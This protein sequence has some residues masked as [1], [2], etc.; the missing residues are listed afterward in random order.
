MPPSASWAAHQFF[1][2]QLPK[3]LEDLNG[4]LVV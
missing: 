3:L 2:D 1:G 4:I